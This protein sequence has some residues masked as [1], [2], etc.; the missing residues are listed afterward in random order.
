MRI[1]FE[2][3][4]LAENSTIELSSSPMLI[5][6]QSEWP[7]T[8]L[9]CRYIEGE[10]Q[11]AQISC[12]L[13]NPSNSFFVD[14]QLTPDV[15]GTDLFIKGV[16]EHQ[17]YYDFVPVYSEVT[18]NH[19]W[20]KAQNNESE[21][22]LSYARGPDTAQVR[23]GMTPDS[24]YNIKSLKK[25]LSIPIIF[26]QNETTY[27]QFSQHP[28]AQCT[29]PSGK[30]LPFCYFKVFKVQKL[31]IDLLQDLSRKQ[32]QVTV[33]DINTGVEGVNSTQVKLNRFFN[34]RPLD[35]LIPAWVWIL[36]LSGTLVLLIVLICGEYRGKERKIEVEDEYYEEEQDVVYF[37]FGAP[38]GSGNNGE[39][40]RSSSN[41]RRSGNPGSEQLGTPRTEEE[42][43]SI[44]RKMTGGLLVRF[45][46]EDDED[47]D[48]GASGE[49]RSQKNANKEK[50]EGLKEKDDSPDEVPTDD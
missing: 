8:S 4:N 9:T 19:I 38:S 6:Y 41:D 34:L 5:Q 18:K 26:T 7:I 39:I 1:W 28:A 16:N 29:T 24:Y 45:V 10:G 42:V 30:V 32:T 17:N 14:L 25:T 48:G 46:C 43:V 40:A 21:V 22:F 15:Q 47:A 37:D 50:I 31:K 13:V 49:Q 2:K 33:L 11:N 36:V 20:V 23:W 12:I 3:V 27:V 35:L 44:D